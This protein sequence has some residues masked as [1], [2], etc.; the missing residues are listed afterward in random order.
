MGRTLT[1][2]Q[3]RT[4]TNHS[5][6]PTGAAPGA[7]A[8][9]DPTTRFFDWWRSTGLRRSSDSWLGGVAGGVAARLGLDPMIV[10]GALIVIAILGGPVLFVYAAGWALI[11][12][13][14]GRIHLERAIRGVFDPA[15]VAIGILA[16][17]TAVPFMRGLWWD[18]V[19]HA[20]NL[21]GWLE[22][23]M[24]AGW[25]IA[26]VAAAVWL[27]VKFSRRDPS[28][29]PTPGTPPQRDPWTSEAPTPTPPA[30]AGAAQPSGTT[31]GSAATGVATVDTV[32]LT[33][34]DSTGGEPTGTAP[35]QNAAHA[36]AWDGA[37]TMQRGWTSQEFRDEMSR[38]R[39]E[40]QAERETKARE[41]RSKQPGAAF[42]AITLGLALLA[43]AGA[44][45]I[46]ASAGFSIPVVVV[47]G[48]AA[49][50]GALA[51]ATIIAGIRGRESGWLGLF[52]WAAVISLLA[53]GVFPLGSTFLPVGRTTWTVTSTDADDRRGYV[54]IAGQPT[55]DLGELADDDA[56]RGGTID[57]WIVAGEVD[58]L[59]PEDVPV[60]VEFSAIAG[61]LETDR[62]GRDGTD[63]RGGALF[64]EEARYGRTSS[65]DTTRVRVWTVA[66]T[67]VVTE[68]AEA[69]R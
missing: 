60:I 20:W 53:T 59:I 7:P 52:T 30:A 38:Q 36:T 33:K 8:P 27:I 57:V 39:A 49:A 61:T 47:I 43:G 14:Q 3:N 10:R 32:S 12:D 42:V 22:S 55:L 64:Q 50:L 6:P 67:T 45:V 48:L 69:G 51:V 31:A 44:A 34:V 40:Q 15:I 26:L 18:G 21:P 11:P 28:Q 13:Q 2:R 1:L 65:S 46:A 17:L 35:V 29:A 56:L 24:T 16:V 54:M 25:V 19:P 66:G 23:T 58:V 63:R 37:P 68:E 4:M 62:D 5:T 9:Q 41:H